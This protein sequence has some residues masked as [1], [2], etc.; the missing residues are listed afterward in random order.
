MVLTRCTSRKPLT[1]RFSVVCRKPLHQPACRFDT[2]S[3]LL[4]HREPDRTDL[5]PSITFNNVIRYLYDSAIRSGVRQGST[6][7]LIPAS[8]CVQR[9]TACAA[10]SRTCSVRSVGFNVLKIF[11]ALVFRCRVVGIRCDHRTCFRHI[12]SPF[13]VWFWLVET[14]SLLPLFL[15]SAD[16]LSRCILSLALGVYASQRLWWQPLFCSFE[17]E[18]PARAMTFPQG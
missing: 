14:T 6:N 5:S 2:G 11:L 1:F 18:W 16:S 4:S 15:L 3:P 9:V 17:D 8:R 13:Q 7:E 12:L 10:G